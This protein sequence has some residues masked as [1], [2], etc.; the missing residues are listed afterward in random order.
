M[1]VNP[2]ESPLRSRHREA[3]SLLPWLVNG[4]LAPPQRQRVER[5]L[6]ECARCR[7]EYEAQHALRAQLFG[8]EVVLD[9]PHAALNK[10]MARIEQEETAAAA[11]QVHPVRSR[12][13]R[14][15]A[16]SVIV[17]AIG[18][19]ALGSVM[20]WKLYELRQAPRYT[21]LAS[22]PPASGHEHPLARVVFSATA[23]AG[24][25]VTLLHSF[26]AQVVAGPTEA[27]VYTLAFPGL[28]HDEGSRAIARLRTHPE[29]LFVESAP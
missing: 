15:L 21:T 7:A 13:T 8:S 12:R 11:P 24:D 5:H 10:L 2:D 26:G 3:W 23:T 16:A 18:L 6:Q 14:W 25:V 20:A 4:S 29:V 1:T 17:Q 27:G 19:I 22:V 9:T 28:A